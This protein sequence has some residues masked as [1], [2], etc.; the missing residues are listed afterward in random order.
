MSVSIVNDHTEEVLRELE[1]RIQAALEACGIQAVS[2]AQDN[3]TKA[4]RVG[5]TGDLRQGISH[6]VKD[7]T[8][9]VGTNTEYAIYNEIGTGKFVAGGRK[10]FWVYVPGSKKRGKGRILSEKEARQLVAILKSKGLDAHMT[11]GMKGIHFL[12]DAIA[13]NIDE[14]KRIIEQHLKG[15]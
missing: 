9:Y 4:G 12:K 6:L 7:K 14:Y 10:G 5:A 8:C 15:G 1:T 13:N 11:E 2:H 3:I